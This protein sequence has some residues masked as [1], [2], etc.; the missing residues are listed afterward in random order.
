MSRFHQ[1]QFPV[2]VVRRF[3]AGDAQAQAQIY[4][5]LGSVVYSMARRILGSPSLAE[6][7][8]Q[9]TFLHAFEHAQSLRDDGA[10]GAWL[11]SIA[12]NQCLMH[13]RSPWHQRRTELPDT[14]DVTAH[15][16]DAS[17]D[18]EAALRALPVRT[19]T[20]VWLHDVEGYTHQQIATLFGKSVSFSKS[21][22][23]RGH[24]QLGRSQNP[25]AGAAPDGLYGEPGQPATERSR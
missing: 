17:I 22:L 16:A 6:E 9:E 1:Q 18:I 11:R 10:V 25:G 24:Q 8:A 20:V 4:G 12:V 3:R 19:R 7:V 14:E 13:M 23:A 5:G 15:D 21:Q 2:D